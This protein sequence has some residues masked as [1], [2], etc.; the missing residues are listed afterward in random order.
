MRKIHSSFPYTN[1]FSSREQRY[2]EPLQAAAQNDPQL[3]T[4]I[5]LDQL[6]IKSTKSNKDHD[7]RNIHDI[8]HAYYDVARTRFVD[9]VCK[10][11]ADWYLINGPETPLRVLSPLFVSLLPDEKLEQI[12]GEEPKVR[13]QRDKLQKDMNSLSEA[14][15]ILS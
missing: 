4:I 11:A 5:R 10:Q 8:L 15:E 9:N 7:V 14:M 6:S 3:G 1:K 13:K 12:A 2:C